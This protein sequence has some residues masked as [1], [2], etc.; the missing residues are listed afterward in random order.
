MKRRDIA[1]TLIASVAGQALG[2]EGAKAVT[3]TP[4][5]IPA[6]SAED[7]SGIPIPYS[8]YE[9][10]DV[11][12][13]GAIG[14]T[15]NAK[16]VDNSVVIQRIFDMVRTTGGRIVFPGGDWSFYL[17]ISHIKGSPNLPVTIDGNGATFRCYASTPR[18]SCVVFGNNSQGR[19]EFLGSGVQF[20]NCNFIGRRYAQQ[21]A[22]DVGYSVLF[23]GTAAVFYNCSFQYGTISGFYAMYGQY[24]EFWSCMFAS[25]T[26]SSVSTGCTLDSHSAAASSNEVLFNRCKFFTC[27]N[28]L[29][30]KGCF[31]TR[32]RDSTFQG[33]PSGG[34]GGVILESDSTGQGCVGTIIDGCWFED[35]KVP[36]ILG[37]I[38][39][40]TKIHKN[41]FYASVGAANRLVFTY[42]YD[43]EVT[44]NVTYTGIVCT[45]SHEP[46][47]TL[48]ASL[49]WHGNNFAPN[50][51]LDHA[52]HSYVD[53]QSAGSRTMR[54]DNM[55]LTTGQQGLN[56]LPLVQSDQ[57]GFKTGI[58]RGV[59]ASLFRIN[60]ESY[61][62]NSCAPVL[63]LEIQLFAWQDTA[64]PTAYA[65]C[66]RAQR[67]YAFITNND[68]T[69][70]TYI[71]S[72]DDGADLGVNVESRMLGKM[73][74]TAS[75]T[76]SLTLGN[77]TATFSASFPGAGSNAAGVT[78]ATIGYKVSAMGGNPF[79]LNRL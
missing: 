78:S 64:E 79:T 51:S 40:G 20:N 21:T 69:L 12:R 13:Y 39:Q 68:G 14:N 7:N 31:L 77:A 17:D 29:A 73:S 1:K 2:E 25:C 24:N 36:H 50:L 65:S 23:N 5:C 74:V 56:G 43:L 10:G 4:P 9:P 71:S 37:R 62:A 19:H 15:T 63:I 8:Q 27:S 22:G 33:A 44:D 61:A 30:V 28:F 45:V 53:I 75:S 58:V 11:R 42:C 76:G 6:T 16:V 18:N 55:L 72:L 67:F 46:A 52:G 70:R 54:N 26:A 47:D 41:N 38:C 34:L 59:A 66:A 35:N 49:S 32:I 3:C 60:L 57:V 48:T